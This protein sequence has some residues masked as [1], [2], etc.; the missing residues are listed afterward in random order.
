MFYLLLAVVVTSGD[1]AMEAFNSLAC[2]FLDDLSSTFDEHQCLEIAHDSLK[3][4][5]EQTKCTPLPVCVFQSLAGGI[6]AETVRDRDPVLLEGLDK[7]VKSAGISL[8]V[9]S[10]YAASD[11]KTKD[12]CH[13]A[14]YHFFARYGAH[15]VECGVGGY[16][17]AGECGFGAG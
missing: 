17:V 13:L 6:E 7:V 10:E 16:C 11:D 14:I 4:M 12:A 8:D 15:L 1:C 5:L 3:K 2:E 9:K